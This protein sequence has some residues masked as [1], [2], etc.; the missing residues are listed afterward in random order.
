MLVFT[1][2]KEISEAVNATIAE[3]L[4]EYYIHLKQVIIEIFFV[5]VLSIGFCYSVVNL[6]LENIFVKVIF[7]FWANQ[8][9]IES[10]YMILCDCVLLE[11]LLVQ[12]EEKDFKKK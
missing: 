7:N 2:M 3:V 1:K 4:H 6:I 5:L 9:S 10:L 8:H 12:W 11:N